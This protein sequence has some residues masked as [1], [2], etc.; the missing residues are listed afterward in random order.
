MAENITASVFFFAVAGGLLPV[1]LWLWFWLKQDINPEPRKILILT[2]LNGMLAVGPAL[3]FEHLISSYLAAGA[4][5]LLLW[6]FT[7]E[8]FKYWAAY[9]T[10]LKR[11]DFDEPIDALIYLITAGLGFASIENIFFI[12]QAFSTDG[13]LSSFITGNLRFVGATLL[14]TAASAIVGA[15]IAFSFFHKSKRAYNILGGI[16]LAGSLHFLFNYFIIK[17][18]GEGALKIFIPLWILIIIIIFIFEKVKRIN[19]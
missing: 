18:N 15:S 5:V 9:E 3:I 4:V 8:I 16:L 6:A 14:H 19:K 2:F 10:A 13:M 17:T 11:P 12:L 7:E 1:L